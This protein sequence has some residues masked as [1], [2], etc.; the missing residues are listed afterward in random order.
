[1]N[2]KSFDRELRKFADY[3]FTDVDLS[4]YSTI[5]VGGVGSYYAKPS[6]VEGLVGLVKLLRK[7]GVPFMPVGN[8]S[9]IYFGDLDGAA[10]IDTRGVTGI[11]SNSQDGSIKVACGTRLDNFVWSYPE[12]KEEIA[13]NLK[14]RNT[15]DMIGYA[16][17]HG[18]DFTRYAG[19]PGTTAGAVVGNA[20]GNMQDTKSLLRGVYVLTPEGDQKFIGRDK[21]GFDYRSSRFKQ[22]NNNPD[23]TKKFTGDLI[24]YAVYED[25]EVGREKVVEDLVDNLLERQERFPKDEVKE[26]RYSLGSFWKRRDGS[27]EVASA[28]VFAEELV[29]QFVKR[30]PNSTSV[31]G[32]SL[33]SNYPIVIINNG[34]GTVD[35][36]EN[37]ANKVTNWVKDEHGVQLIREVEKIDY[38]NA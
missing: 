14:N 38:K 10:L 33:Y 16:L 21:L 37:L 13:N 6:T 28:N 25:V 17:R 31:G 32:V 7:E 8:G 30:N 1:M 29:K 34:N 19:I 18:V 4:K 36:L 27:Y 5:G 24:L 26:W 2:T 9:N 11:E 35:D 12:T 22:Q 23:R 20:A 3:V 15:K